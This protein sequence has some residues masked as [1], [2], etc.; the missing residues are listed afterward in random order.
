[1]QLREVDQIVAHRAQVALELG[2]IVVVRRRIGIEVQARD[3]WQRHALHL[4]AQ[5]REISARVRAWRREG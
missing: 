3:G 4:G 5:R 2:G 1:M